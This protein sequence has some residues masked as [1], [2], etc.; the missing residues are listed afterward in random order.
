MSNSSPTDASPPDSKAAPGKAIF[1]FAAGDD[2]QLRYFDETRQQRQAASRPSQSER[3]VVTISTD[4][5][6]TSTSSDSAN[7]ALLPVVSG[8][9]HQAPAPAGVLTEKGNEELEDAADKKE[10]DSDPS[11]LA[12]E[13]ESPPAKET[14]ELGRQDLFLP[15]QDLN[16]TVRF[17]R[18][19]SVAFWLYV[20]GCILSVGI[21]YLIC[22]FWAPKLYRKLV[23]RFRAAPTEA[24]LLRGEKVSCLVKIPSE[25]ATVEPLQLHQLPTPVPSNKIFTPNMR[26]PFRNQAEIPQGISRSRLTH[27]SD[28]NTLSQFH[29][30]NFRHTPLI[31]HGPSQKL[32][33]FAEWRDTDIDA[34]NGGVTPLS[35]EQVAL[36]KS[37][38]GQNLID[39]KGQPLH[40]LIV[41]ECL[42]P[43]YVF[44]LASCGLWFVSIEQQDIVGS[45]PR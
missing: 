25:P 13:L 15:A 17:M 18:K 41:E 44:T 32:V 29:L 21:L 45:L 34:A 9:V 43:F 38:F 31:Y 40:K 8:D 2:S 26:I 27:A 33:N 16:M 30:L 6:V 23:Y 37:L 10:S 14:S 4:P 36:R 28:S 3:D 1:Q 42:H 12:I 24:E 35:T 11:H 39:V 5:T 19:S 22:S 20:V 7:Y